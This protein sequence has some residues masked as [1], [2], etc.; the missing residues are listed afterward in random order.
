MT[1]HSKCHPGLPLPHGEAQPGS[2]S[3]E[4]FHNTKSI[5]F[6]F[7]FDTSILDPDFSSSKFLFDS[8]P[9]FLNEIT[10]KYSFEWA[11]KYQSFKEIQKQTTDTLTPDKKNSINFIR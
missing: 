4:G 5:G 9:Y 10:E 6:F 1:E 11:G 8:F 2:S 3:I 7:R